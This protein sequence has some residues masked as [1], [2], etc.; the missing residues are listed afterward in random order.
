MAI[1]AIFKFNLA[2]IFNN[3]F[4][5]MVFYSNFLMIET[6]YYAILIKNLRKVK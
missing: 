2:R 6:K 4:D 5:H 3:S 1:T